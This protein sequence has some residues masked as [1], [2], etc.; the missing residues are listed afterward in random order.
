MRKKVV[1]DEAQGRKRRDALRDSDRGVSRGFSGVV[2]LERA[3]Q[4]TTGTSPNS[5]FFVTVFC[6][7]TSCTKCSVCHVAPMNA[8]FFSRA[9]S[10]N[11]RLARE[12]RHEGFSRQAKR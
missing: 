6:Y 1:A 3:A 12:M 8:F 4:S 2:W 5:P 9:R 7:D 10:N 11:K